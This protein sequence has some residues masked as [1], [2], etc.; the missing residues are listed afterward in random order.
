MAAYATQHKAPNG[1]PAHT[2]CSCLWPTCL[3][4]SPAPQP[5]GCSSHRWYNRPTTTTDHA[6]ASDNMDLLTVLLLLLLGCWARLPTPPVAFCTCCQ[7][8]LAGS[9]CQGSHT[10]AVHATLQPRVVITH[11]VL[12]A[13]TAARTRMP[14]HPLHCKARPP[15]GRTKQGAGASRWVAHSPLMYGV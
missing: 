9:A 11:H 7:L 1:I 5:A 10:H 2:A 4:P 6:T 12:Q 15:A 14:P 8:Q 13:C 3:L